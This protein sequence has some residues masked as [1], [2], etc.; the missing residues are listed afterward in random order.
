M[1]SMLVESNL[2]LREL[3]KFIDIPGDLYEEAGLVIDHMADEHT[4]MK[5]S[6]FVD[7]CL[8]IARCKMKSS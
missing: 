1:S 2:E 7:M 3:A 4:H 6:E 8:N 5:V